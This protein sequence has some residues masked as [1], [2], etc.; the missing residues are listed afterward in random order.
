M[1]FHMYQI[2]Q[3]LI[4]LITPYCKLNRLIYEFIDYI[5][6]LIYQSYL[7]DAIKKIHIL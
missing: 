5:Y 6:K 4:L 1:S 2:I 7:I 3:L